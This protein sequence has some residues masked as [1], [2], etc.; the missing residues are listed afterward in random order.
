MTTTDPAAVEAEKK[1]NH[2]LYLRR[3]CMTSRVVVPFADLIADAYAEHINEIR[4]EWRETMQEL[5]DAMARLTTERK[6]RENL[7]EL[8]ESIDCWCGSGAKGGDCSR[9]ATLAEAEKLE[10]SAT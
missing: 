7:V 2:E 8:V 9:C 5:L 10:A 1:I 6:L 4:N 3:A